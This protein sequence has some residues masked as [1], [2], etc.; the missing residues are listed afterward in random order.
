[1]NKYYVYINM[2]NEIATLLLAAFTGL[3]MSMI[4]TSGGSAL[5]LYLFDKLK[6]IKSPTAIAGTMLLIGLLPL[7]LAGIYDFYI[8]N[9]I[10]YRA[11]FFMSIGLMVGIHY[12]AEYGYLIQD[13]FGPKTGDRI[14][15]TVT[16]VIYG[17]LT[18]LYISNAYYV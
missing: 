7:G 8:H 18:L 15:Y 2:F 10:D 17:F 5:M 13:K 4:G 16:A 1:M 11:A 3:Y 9:D 6:I 12:G 14:K